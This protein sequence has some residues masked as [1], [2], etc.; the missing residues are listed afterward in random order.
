MNII[1]FGYR[2]SGKTTIGKRLAN[3]LWKTFVDVDEQTC[4]RFG[5]DSIAAIWDEHGEPAFR[6]AETEVTK[7]LCG[8][9]D[10]VISLGGGA[11][12][13]AEARAAVEQAADAARIY[14]FCEPDELFRRISADDHSDKT[15][16]NLTPLGGGLEEIEA[17]LA[18]RDPVYRAVADKV[19]DVTH[20]DPVNACR[21]LIAKCL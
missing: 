17:V 3:Q 2:G 13:Q 18:E 6:A 5:N 8:R 12:M 15:R 19:F 4:R 9:T 7:E 10:L 1:L 16:P 21:Y 20:L 11:L 14:L